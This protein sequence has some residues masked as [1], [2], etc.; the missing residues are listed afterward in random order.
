MS[1]RIDSRYLYWHKYGSVEDTF[2][3]GWSIKT[4]ALDARTKWLEKV[5]P[6]EKHTGKHLRKRSLG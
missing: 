5:S 2:N 1:T 4:I 6:T 3:L